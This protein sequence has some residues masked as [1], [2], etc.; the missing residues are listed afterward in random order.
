MIDPKKIEELISS[1]TKA[2]IPVH[3]AGTP[4]DMK[5]IMKISKNNSL[6]VVEDCAHAIGTHFNKKHVGNLGFAMDKVWLH[7][8]RGNNVG[9]D[10]QQE[11]RF[12]LVKVMVL[13]NLKTHQIWSR[14]IPGSF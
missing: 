7:H 3:F 10:I 2:I 1:K 12:E 8:R 9:Y 13:W 4:C 6:N 14:L 5:E 11:K